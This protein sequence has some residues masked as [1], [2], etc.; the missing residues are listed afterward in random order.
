MPEIGWGIC[1][2]RSTSG[3]EPP[4]ACHCF[5]GLWVSSLAMPSVAALLF[6]LAIFWQVQSNL[7]FRTALITML[8]PLNHCYDEISYFLV[9][10]SVWDAC[11]TLCAYVTPCVAPEFQFFIVWLSSQGCVE[12]IYF[13]CAYTQ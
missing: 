3:R 12:A 6:F 11:F 8:M 4:L 13:S 10:F 7:S 1:W 9:T 5:H 2:T